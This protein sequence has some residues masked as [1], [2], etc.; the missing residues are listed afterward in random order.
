MDAKDP[1][2]HDF[3]WV[4]GVT[5]ETGPSDSAGSGVRRRSSSPSSRIFCVK[6]VMISPKV[7][8]AL[9]VMRSVL[10]KIVS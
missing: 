4:P 7:T 2:A 9:A 6:Y 10:Y 8:S 1:P 3:R 5:G